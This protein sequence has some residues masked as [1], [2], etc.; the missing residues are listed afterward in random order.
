MWLACLIVVYLLWLP[1]VSAQPPGS[2]YSGPGSTMDGSCPLTSCALNCQRWQYRKGCSF[3]SSGFCADCTGLTFH[4]Y[5]SLSGG[6][7]DSCVQSPQKTCTAGY[8]NLNRNSTFEGDCTLCAPPTADYYFTTPSSPSSGCE[9]ALRNPCAVGYRDANY[10][11]PFLPPNCT[12]CLNIPEGH[13][14][15]SRTPGQCT[16]ERKPTCPTGHY[17]T[18]YNDP[19]Q[20]GTCLPCDRLHKYRGAE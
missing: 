2:F 6:L 1:V 8:V 20:N 17:L 11:N 10:N 3:N 7:T 5:F 13:Y 15:V 4:K 9:S 19:M 14:W 12:Q 18:G 16:S